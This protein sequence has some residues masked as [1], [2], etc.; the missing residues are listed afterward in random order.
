[1]FQKVLFVFG[2]L[3]IQSSVYTAILDEPSICLSRN[4]INKRYSRGRTEKLEERW[5][6]LLCRS[7]RVG[8]PSMRPWAKQLQFGLVSSRSVLSWFFLSVHLVFCPACPRLYTYGRAG[9]NL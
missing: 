7:T 9:I 1:M 4:D 6:V 5:Q 2:R 3:R 8:E